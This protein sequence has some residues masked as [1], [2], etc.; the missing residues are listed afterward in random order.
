MKKIKIIIIM[1][2]LLMSLVNAL[3]NE[4]LI[5]HLP[6]DEATSPSIDLVK[7]S[8]WEWNNTPQRGVNYVN[9]N[10]SGN[11]GEYSLYM[12]SNIDGMTNST[13][14]TDE[15][16]SYNTAFS[17]CLFANITDKGS[18]NNYILT[19]ESGYFYIREDLNKLQVRSF[20]LTTN[21]L[22][23][24]N[25]DLNKYFMICY[26]NSAIDT[27]FYHAEIGEKNIKSETLT[28]GTSTLPQS[29]HIGID[30][31]ILF[32]L[33]GHIDHLKIYNKTI[34]DSEV[35]NY[36]NYG[37]IEGLTE[38]IN[39]G[40]NHNI[41]Y[42]SDNI[43]YYYQYNNGTNQGF[44]NHT[45]TSGFN[46]YTNCLSSYCFNGTTT[47]NN[48]NINY[49]DND[50]NAW[51]YGLWVKGNISNKEFFT[52][53]SSE[54]EYLKLGFDSN[55]KP[56]IRS[57]STLETMEK[58]MTGISSES[59]NTTD[60]TYLSWSRNRGGI[61]PNRL[62]FLVN[63]ETYY[64]WFYSDSGEAL[65]NNFT[66]NI[67]SQTI[68][69]SELLIDD[70]VLYFA[71]ELN[72][73]DIKYL[74]EQFMYY[75]EQDINKEFFPILPPVNITIYAVCDET[76]TLATNIS[77]NRTFNWSEAQDPQYFTVTYSVR[78]GSFYLINETLETSFDY[79][80]Q[81]PPF[82]HQEYISE[83]EAC[84]PYACSSDS[85]SFNVCISNWQEQ[86]SQCTGNTQTK[87]YIDTNNCPISYNIP[88]DNNT[89]VDCVNE[90]LEAELEQK[91]DH[92]LTIIL[93][94][95]IILLFILQL[96]M[97]KEW[98]LSF[99]ALF[100]NLTLIILLMVNKQNTDFYIIGGLMFLF[101]V[102]LTVILYRSSK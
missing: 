8:K 25:Y 18:G 97:S 11:G 84:N 69:S 67:T 92:F 20:S 30:F 58:N 36:F 3:E 26:V 48:P 80:F 29:L 41:T 55:Q 57:S 24:S 86:Y 34:N 21:T 63:N 75:T 15:G 89:L 76:I 28:K 62:T 100:I 46:N 43:G 2:I 14:F 54:G 79:S 71:E 88:N 85:C 77:E 53:K 61:N 72:T 10:T 50:K 9:F 22:T 42:Y 60:W 49:K 66:G 6:F 102:A 73:S 16:L 40:I 33:E 64:N 65:P 23:D 93:I 51:L 52:I 99:V 95:L 96:V 4:Y 74:N 59:I 78:A 5:T 12:D 68:N 87:T 45:I 82:T 98:L 13:Y 17:I 35:Y 44:L 101:Q 70:T 90:D 37:N 1:F 91:E 31:S 81:T 39:Y 27:K 32:G 47:H 38:K 56:Y 83:V 94:G 7:N 19:D